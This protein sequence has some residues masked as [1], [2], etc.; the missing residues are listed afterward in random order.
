MFVTGIRDNDS[1][2]KFTTLKL[3]FSVKRVKPHLAP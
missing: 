1:R 2:P 3:G